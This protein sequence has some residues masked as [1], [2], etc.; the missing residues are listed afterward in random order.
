VT[1]ATVAWTPPVWTTAG[2][3]G[4]DQQTPNIAS[5]IQEI[6][7]RAGWVAGNSM[8][9][10]I[11]GFG[12]RAA[13]A[14]DGDVVNGTNGAPLLHVEY[15][16]GSVPNQS[17]LMVQST[18]SPLDANGDGG[19]SAVDALV[20]INYLSTQAASQGEGEMPAQDYDTNGDGSVSALDVL[21]VINYLSR[22][23]ATAASESEEAFAVPL[24]DAVNPAPPGSLDDDLIRML[25]DDQFN[26]DD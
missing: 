8:A 13:V 10:F 9:L 21:Q 16:T 18:V 7:D 11:T 26:A 25:A 3:A 4:I 2:E 23:N 22:S 1:N 14:Y 12:E 15:T 6:V 24:L 17:P 19:V 20:I 5:I